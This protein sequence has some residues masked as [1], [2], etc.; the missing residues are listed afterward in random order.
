MKL[1]RWMFGLMMLSLAASSGCQLFHRDR[2]ACGGERRG[3]FGFLG[4][5]R[6]ESC[7]IAVGGG[8]DCSAPGCATCGGG[9]EMPMMNAPM[10]AG[11]AGAAPDERLGAPAANRAW[12]GTGAPPA[13][14]PKTGAPSR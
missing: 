7:G 9:G 13:Q 10:F 1:R 11:P 6:V 3:L 2:C 12:D 5:R 14:L 4:K 8:M